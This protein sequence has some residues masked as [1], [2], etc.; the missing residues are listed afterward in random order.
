LSS[1][2]HPDSHAD[3]ELLQRI[4]VAKENAFFEELVEIAIELERVRS[5]ED[6]ATIE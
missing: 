1:G 4:A 2:E 3:L 5:G 6:F